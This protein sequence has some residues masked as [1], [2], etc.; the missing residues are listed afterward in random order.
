VVG[1]RGLGDGS[2]A[3]LAHRVYPVRA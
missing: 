1:V 3:E 2:G